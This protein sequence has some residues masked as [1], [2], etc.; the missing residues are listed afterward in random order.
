MNRLT[1]TALTVAALLFGTTAFAQDKI[2]LRV[3]TF[4]PSSH[5]Q[6][7][8]GSNVWMEEVTRLTN[9]LVEFEYYPAEQMGKAAQ[10]LDLMTA[11][12]VDIAEI[13]PAYVTDKLPLLGVL[14]MPG[15]V[16]NACEGSKA[17]RALSEPGGTIYES[18]FAPSNVRPLT[19]FIY[20][21]YSI[22][23]RTPFSGIESFAGQKMRTSGGAM[24][25]VA[26]KLGAAPVRM[27]APEIFQSLQRG[28][29]D[30]VMFSFLS[31]K[32]ADMGAVATDAAYGFGFGAPS[33]VLS[34][35]EDKFA[36]LPP[37]VQDA[38]I[39]AGVVADDSYC[40]YVDANEATSRDEM[41]AAGIRIYTLS[42][43]EKARLA[44]TLA[45]VSVSWAKGLDDR[46]KPATET[47]QE[48]TSLVK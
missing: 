13:P 1:T 38:M 36:A 47:L 34:M 8:N 12:V 35:A 4:L 27:P 21:P 16:P 39:E 37:E 2:R 44:E 6:V 19:F 31:A 48:F 29:L 17:L 42:E 5:F 22:I 40:R 24:E 15:L 11:G 26:A 45:D 20:P 33:V 25:L 7:V 9:G 32:D 10:L 41:E 18:D 30:S 43:E 23:M 14:E 28:T 3:A 46:G